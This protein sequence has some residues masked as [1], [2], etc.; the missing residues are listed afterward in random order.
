MI[1]NV[2]VDTADIAYNDIVI[3]PIKENMN[4]GKTYA[5]FHWAASNAWVP[6]LYFDH[7][8]FESVPKNLSYANQTTPE[9]VLAEHDPIFAHRDKATGN[10]KPW[11]RPDFLIK[12]DDDSFVMLA[13]LEAHLRVELHGG[14]LPVRYGHQTELIAPPA[15]PN[16]S[17]IWTPPNNDPLI[18][19]GYLVK[20][21]FMGGELYALSHG[22]GAR[23]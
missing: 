4:D 11:V 8:Q 5:Y 23:P 22:L 3:L 12:A 17:T 19:W 20:N 15:S 2:S 10:P 6:P 1:S 7:E 21:R 13:E 18:F 16:Q 9:P 14:P